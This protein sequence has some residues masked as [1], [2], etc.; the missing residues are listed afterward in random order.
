MG[1]FRFLTYFVFAAF[2]RQQPAVAPFPLFRL[3]IR[4][5]GE[6]WHPLFFYES[7]TCKILQ[8]ASTCSR[9]LV[10]GLQMLIGSTGS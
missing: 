5:I 3:S 8:D 2:N 1:E 4:N 9:Y 7:Y 6:K 10:Y